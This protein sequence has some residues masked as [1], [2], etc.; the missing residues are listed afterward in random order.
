MKNSFFHL[1]IILDGNRRWA[2]K[3]GLPAAIGHKKG[4]ENLR[5]L[6]PAFIAHGIT[7]LTVFAL[8]TE[9]LKERNTSELKN[10]FR[11]IELF[12]KDEEIFRVNKI[13]L[14]LFGN[15]TKFPTTT[16]KVLRNLMERTKNYRELTLNLAL[17]YGGRDEIVRAANKF[18]KSGRRATEKSFGETL[19]S[20]RQ[21]D[22][23]LLIRTGGK[24]R[25][26]N[27]LIWQLAYA[28]LYFTEKMWPEFNEVELKKAL[29]WFHE[30]KRTFG[31]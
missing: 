17:D 4:A 28:E 18:V 21:S 30:Q 20:G 26:S 11:G 2:R 31:K 1:A 13:R 3:R 7:H 9:N 25:I 12:A 24:Q 27:F 10:I 15:L 29:E 14:Q 22:P 6:L 19:D 5:K 23:D 16:K 8:S